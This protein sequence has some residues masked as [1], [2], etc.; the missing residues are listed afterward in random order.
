MKNFEKK[1]KTVVLVTI[2]GA[3]LFFFS[4][5]SVNDS[6]LSMYNALENKT[7]ILEMLN[8]PTVVSEELLA[9]I[10]AENAKIKIQERETRATLVQITAKQEIAIQKSQRAMHAINNKNVLRTTVLGNNLGTL[11]FQLVQIKGLQAMLNPL[12]S[13]TTDVELKTQIKNQIE[14]LKKEQEEIE[15]VLQTLR[16]RFSLLGWIV[17]T[18]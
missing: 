14:Y 18:I 6:S 2:I 4:N 11:E 8:N 9:Q 13:K 5:A 10:M 17:A 7:S 16:G 1:N 3:S 12:I 15:A